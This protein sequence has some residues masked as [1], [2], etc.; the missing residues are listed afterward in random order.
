[1][2]SPSAPYLPLPLPQGARTLSCVVVLHCTTAQPELK[3]MSL[4][5]WA[6]ATCALP[7]G[8][9]LI[10]YLR[11]E[12]CLWFPSALL[13][14]NTP[15]RTRGTNM[16]ACKR[17]S[18][19]LGVLQQVRLDYR[20]HLHLDVES[21]RHGGSTCEGRAV[22]DI[23]DSHVASVPAVPE[24]ILEEESVRTRG[25]APHVR[26]SLEVAQRSRGDCDAIDLEADLRTPVL[27]EQLH[28]EI[29]RPCGAACN[30][31]R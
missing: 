29:A 15:G 18:S 23:V 16:R 21:G 20:L 28:R 8:R 10:T 2:R 7:K 31:R 14:P 1:M 22:V 27:C 11:A 24:G 5:A 3:R 6:P 9:L 17:Q 26:V 25:E 4:Y 30:R 19:Q 12:A 13:P